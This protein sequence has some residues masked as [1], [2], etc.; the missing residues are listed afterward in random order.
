MFTSGV[1]QVGTRCKQRSV[2][3]ILASM[4][5]VR[6]GL[7]GIHCCAPPVYAKPHG[8]RRGFAPRPSSKS[9]RSMGPEKSTT[10]CTAVSDGIWAPGRHRHRGHR[11]CPRGYNQRGR[12]RMRKCHHPPMRS[13]AM[14]V[15]WRWRSREADRGLAV[16]DRLP[17]T[18][19]VGRKEII[20]RCCDV[21]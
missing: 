13:G 6:A 3:R 18:W 1:G 8:H 7:P 4:Y 16:G 5:V 20:N 10:H 21:K 2:G 12:V 19:A 17:G 14:T 9:T 15:P 11:C